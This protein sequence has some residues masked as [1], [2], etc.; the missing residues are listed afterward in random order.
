MSAQ[1]ANPDVPKL[2]GPR[3]R[4]SS[5]LQTDRALSKLFVAS[6]GQRFA[7]YFH[8]EV[9]AIGEYIEAAPFAGALHAVR[10]RRVDPDDAAGRRGRVWIADV[11]LVAAAKTPWIRRLLT[12]DEQSAVGIFLAPEFGGQLEVAERCDAAQ[13]SLRPGLL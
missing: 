2:H 9:R 7:V 10:Q 13:E 6:V 11:D 5:R 8:N 12:A 1:R 3:A 4:G